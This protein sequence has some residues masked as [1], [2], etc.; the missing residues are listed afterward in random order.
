MKR[1]L[2]K[3]P[4]SLLCAVALIASLSFPVAAFL[5]LTYQTAG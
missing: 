5:V 2:G 4:L 3:K 1:S